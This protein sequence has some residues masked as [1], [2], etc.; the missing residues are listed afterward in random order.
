MVNAD[1]IDTLMKH[2]L[3][4]PNIYRAVFGWLSVT[5]C[6]SRALETAICRRC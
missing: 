5:G 3:T 2:R 6:H 1:N 4:R